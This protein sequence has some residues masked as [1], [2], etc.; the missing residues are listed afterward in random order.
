MHGLGPLEAEVMD[1]V[2]A[3]DGA[4]RVREVI[5]RMPHQQLAYTTVMTVLDKLHRKGWLARVRDGR[6]YCYRSVLSREAYCAALMSEV[7]AA[8]RDPG[9]TLLRFVQALPA[10]LAD[11]LVRAAAARTVQDRA[12]VTVAGTGSA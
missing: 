10:E 3:A 8:S 5:E 1:V 4:L 12:A 6:A 9:E 2:W 11:Q 7:L